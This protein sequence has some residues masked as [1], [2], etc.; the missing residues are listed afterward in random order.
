MDKIDGWMTIWEKLAGYS[1]V[2]TYSASSISK[3][4]TKTQFEVAQMIFKI[5]YKDG[6]LRTLQSTFDASSE[7][8]YY[9]SIDKTDATALDTT[10]DGMEKDLTAAGGT[11]QFA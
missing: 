11:A 2:I 4:Q 6:G 8:N 7:A 5:M 3:L 1:K 9:T 10:Y